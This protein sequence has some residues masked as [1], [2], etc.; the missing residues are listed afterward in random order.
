M[1]DFPPIRLFGSQIHCNDFL[2]SRIHIAYAMLQTLEVIQSISK[3]EP[4][5]LR[6]L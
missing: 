2:N 6:K 1:R 5:Y 4:T 3:S